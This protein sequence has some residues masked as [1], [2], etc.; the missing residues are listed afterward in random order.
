MAANDCPG[1]RSEAALVTRRRKETRSTS[2]VELYTDG[3]CLGN[4]GPGGWAALLRWQGREKMLQGGT[5]ETTNNRMEMQAVAEGLEALRKPCDVEVFTDSQYVCRG[6]TEWM[7]R[8]RKNAWR[9]A[10]R[11]PVKNVD[12]WKRLDAAS[13]GHHIRWQW[14]RGHSGHPENER[15]DEAA[16]GQANAQRL[17]LEGAEPSLECTSR[18][19][20]AVA[21]CAR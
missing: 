6:M 8:W 20:P 21:R 10:D 13:S 15:V 14:V 16:R 4:P 17:R 19:E 12:L 7:D 5:V 11:R 18:N 9:T 2:S 3:A 1:R